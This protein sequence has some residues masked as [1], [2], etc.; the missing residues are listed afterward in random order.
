MLDE[1]IIDHII[2]NFE[3]ANP[4]LNIYFICEE[5]HNPLGYK[6]IKRAERVRSFNPKTDSI[7]N[8]GK[9]IKPQAI[10]F[11]S[12]G[13]GFL[14]LSL[15][16]SEIKSFW[17]VWGYDIYQLP[18]ILPSLYAPFTKR[19]IIESNP[20][21]YFEW[22]IKKSRF[23]SNFYYRLIG[24][25]NPFF[26]LEKAHQNLDYFV[27]YIRED[28]DKY[29]SFYPNSRIRYLHFSFLTLDQYLGETLKE[30]VING[31]NILIGN[32]N[33]R[34]S[35]HIDV[36][37]SIQNGI[38]EQVKVFVPLNYGRD[39]KYKDAVIKKGRELLKNSF[40]PIVHFMEFGDYSKI[41]SSCS[42]GIFYHFRQ[43]AMGNII[44]ML[45]LGA[46]VYLSKKNPVF[47]YLIRIGILVFDLERDFI[48]FGN[49]DLTDNEKVKNRN[50]LR[51]V[52]SNERVED[53]YK[54]FIREA[55]KKC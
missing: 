36:F 12:F 41:L 19:L 5:K 3:S 9:Q 33:S 54:N 21:I 34:E 20:F 51:T 37:Y 28:F 30:G 45:W 49:N 27:T 7:E 32:S 4:G 15:K 26:L 8:I 14:K 47:A 24:Q 23:L 46:R 1:K 52:F 13:L 10:V 6:Y 39:D 17:I 55:Y 53:E 42:I 25:K 38:N 43:Q 40:L 44:A 11:H 2:D 18:R 48:F 29:I 50:V 35:N 16:T 31:K 22:C